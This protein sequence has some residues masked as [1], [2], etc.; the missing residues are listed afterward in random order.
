MMV[1]SPGHCWMMDF[2]NS[3]LNCVKNASE[4]T[5]SHGYRLKIHSYDN[6]TACLSYGPFILSQ[7][8][9]FDIISL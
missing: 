8:Y 3:V 7:T 5:N 2:S 9:H 4:S 1:P 6:N